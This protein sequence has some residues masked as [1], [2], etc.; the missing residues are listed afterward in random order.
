MR[1]T[2]RQLIDGKNPATSCRSV[3]LCR[4][5]RRGRK[6]ETETTRKQINSTVLGAKTPKTWHKSTFTLI[7]DRAPKRSQARP[8]H[9]FSTPDFAAAAADYRR[10]LLRHSLQGQH[11]KRR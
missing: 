3:V 7:P 10:V 9:P 5:F 6:P 4:C 1:L 8:E 2:G 11:L